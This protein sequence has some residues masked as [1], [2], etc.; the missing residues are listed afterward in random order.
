MS[1]AKD[2]EMLET[3]LLDRLHE[4]FGECDHIGRSDR[5]SLGFEQSWLV[6]RVPSLTFWS[7][8]MRRFLAR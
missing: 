3:F 7:N 6:R 2:D 5:S 4:S 1:A 8:R